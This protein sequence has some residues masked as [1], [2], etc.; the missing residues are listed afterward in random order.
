VFDLA[1]I[2][3]SGL[4]SQ[5][6]FHESL[7]S[8]NDQALEIGA[9]GDFKLPLL[10]LTQRQTAGRGRGANRWLT[11]DGALT[12]SLVLEAVAERLPLRNRPQVALVAGVAVAEA[13]SNYVPPHSVQLKWPNDVFVEGSKIGGILSESIPGWTERFVIGIGINVNNRIRGSELSVT[14]RSLVDDDGVERDLTSVLVTVLDEFDR[15][16]NEL[17]ENGF[18]SASNAYRE[19]CFLTG[20]IVTVAQHD[21]SHLVGLCRGIDEFGGLIVRTAS[22]A[23]SLISGSVVAWEG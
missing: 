6:D 17:L 14:A 22:G 8:T 13:L 10:V 2:Q 12:F 5:I 19:R 21:G 3:E 1:R 15:R 16:W 7:G 4:V 11:S 20:K 18:V 23:R 9:I